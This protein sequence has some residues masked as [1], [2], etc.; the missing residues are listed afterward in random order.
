[1]GT[2]QLATELERA[3]EMGLRTVSTHPCLRHLVLRAAEQA[4][5]KNVVGAGRPKLAVKVDT[6]SEGR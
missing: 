5:A 4:S 2:A 1:M 6:S 3:M